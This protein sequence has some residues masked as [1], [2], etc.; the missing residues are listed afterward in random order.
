MLELLCSI[1]RRLERVWVLFG[2]VFSVQKVNI[3]L[4]GLTNANP[5]LPFGKM[6][7]APQDLADKAKAKL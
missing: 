5:N 4:F 7:F 3:F 2:A 6:A 1:G